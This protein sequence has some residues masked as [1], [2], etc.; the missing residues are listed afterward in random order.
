MTA[1]RFGDV[2]RTSNSTVERGLSP[3]L[4]RGALPRVARLTP[5]VGVFAPVPAVTTFVDDWNAIEL[6]DRTRGS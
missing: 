2:V 5:P 3:L 6:A 4:P 1:V